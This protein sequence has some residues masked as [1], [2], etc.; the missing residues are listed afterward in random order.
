MAPTNVNP[1]VAGAQ[2]TVNGA[3]DQA[4]FDQALATANNILSTSRTTIAAGD[5]A[6]AVNNTKTLASVVQAAAQ[7]SG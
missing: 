6:A 3:S 5:M 4:I 1:I 2:S 7:R